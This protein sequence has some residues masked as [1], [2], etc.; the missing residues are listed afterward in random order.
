MD[1]LVKQP[2]RLAPLREEVHCLPGPTQYDG[3]PSWTL[4]DPANNRFFR[5][6]WLEHEILLRWNLDDPERIALSICEDTV[7][8]TDHDTVM[9]FAE[10]LA[11][12]Q[13]L[14]PVG[15]EAVQRL[16]KQAL[17]SRKS[18][19]QWLV[20]NYLFF[21]IPLFRPDPFLKW[22][23][24]YLRWIYTRH[25]L[26][27]MLFAWLLSV[28]L[29]SRQWDV[30][31]NTFSSF[32]NWQ[33]L[34]QYFIALSFAKIL[35]ELGH[36]LTA[37][38]FGCRVPTM[39]VAFMVMYPMLYTDASELWTLNKRSQRLAIGAAGMIAELMLAVLAALLWNVLD[40]GALRSAV[41]LLASST[42][43]M[44]L[45]VNLS[46]FM[47]FDGY[48]L[49]SDWVKIENLQPRA[50]TYTRWQL[51]RWL[52][53]DQSEPPEQVP[54]RTARFFVIY[55]WSTWIYRLFLFL[56][57]AWM[58]YQFFFKVLGIILMLVEVIWFV[59]MPVWKEIK[60]W[61]ILLKQYSGHRLGLAL[62]IL[63]LVVLL[64]WQEHQTL[65]ALLKPSRYAELYLP[66]AARIDEWQVVAGQSV[67]EGDILISLSSHDLN[68]KARLA[69]L[70]YHGYQRE[71]EFKGMDG[72][73]IKQR[74]IQLKQAES[75]F[76]R[77]A[78]YQ[79]QIDQLQI[80]API[81]GV[82]RYINDEAQTGQWLKAGE[83][84]LIIADTEAWQLEAYVNEQAVMSLQIGATGRFYPENPES[85]SIAC[86]IKAIEL[87]NT[88]VMNN[89]MASVFGGPV[90][91]RKN[92]DGRLIP[93]GAQYRVILE[94]LESPNN[95]SAPLVIRGVVRVE[96]EANSLLA[97]FWRKAWATLRREAG[98]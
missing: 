38:R 77:E 2:K 35:H 27:G 59:A 9:Q 50:F 85:P 15:A 53:A 83:S 93:D 19:L 5:I 76:T 6:G 4:H 60:D 45:M 87:S 17:A 34:A 67:S 46:P 64:P 96:S 84:L 82:V 62:M 63:G 68:H 8:N 47:R 52:F 58:V 18:P 20:H 11:N 42:W 32:F 29:I 61:P 23:Y 44:T 33:G 22:L 98:F 92:S 57:I 79:R 54:P 90:A 51:R 49:L 12:Q 75:A 74:Q 69:G 24:P 94:G 26:F 7:L 21:K 31:L 78:G 30:F 16:K 86:R 71:L 70:E 91:S 73:L 43:I 37:H 89:L 39:G 81:T 13:L 10:F 3:S 97:Q 1:R 72:R 14:Y 65:P 48:Y 41:F 95:E 25:C 88:P 40:E 80:H 28:Y 56:G 55:S 66:Y 36:A